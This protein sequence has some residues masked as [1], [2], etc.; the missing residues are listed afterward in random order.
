MKRAPLFLFLSLLMTGPACGG[1]SGLVSL[2]GDGDGG[3]TSPD[4]KAPPSRCTSLTPVGKATLEFNDNMKMY[5]RVVW[6]GERF[7]V[8]WHSQ[9]SIISSMNGDLR[10]AR[11]DLAAKADNKDGSI[12]DSDNGLMPS[13]LVATPGE[14][15]LV[16]LPVAKTQVVQRRLMDI[17]GATRHTTN[18]PVQ[19]YHAAI[20]SH[21]DGHALL[22]AGNGGVPVLGYLDRQGKASPMTSLITAQVMASLWLAPRPGGYAAM[23]HS[24]NSNATLYRFDANLKQQSM[25]SVGHGALVR[26]VDMAVRPGGFTSL[27]LT[28]SGQV[29]AEP[30][31]GAGK[32]GA[33]TVVAKAPASKLAPGR[34]AL[35]WTGEQLVATYPG[36]GAGQFRLR[37]LSGVGKPEGAEIKL[38]NCLAVAQGGVSA[39]WGN[40]HLAVAVVNSASGI[41]SNAVCVSVLKCQ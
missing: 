32:R 8:V 33:S 29:E 35:T 14:L 26:A 34:V 31:D 21:P 6:D 9:L 4:S 12:L 24:T 5:P 13:A 7:T 38:P 37:L 25:S 18:L 11:V 40:G 41:P 39:A 10:R 22:L 15:A 17:T 16:H 36:L 20:T 28:D 30:Y 3:V 23:L 2:A 27:Y 1:R 19:A